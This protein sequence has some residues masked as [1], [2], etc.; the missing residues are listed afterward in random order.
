MLPIVNLFIAIALTLYPLCSK[1]SEPA[2]VEIPPDKQRLIGVK[3]GTVKVAPF[4]KTIRTNGRL[5]FDERASVV[6]SSQIGGWVERLYADYTGYYVKKGDPLLEIYSPELLTAQQEYLNLLNWAS[7]YAS[8]EPKSEIER[9]FLKDQQSLIESAK[10]RLKTWHMT[11]EQ[12]RQIEE[13]KKPIRT[14]AL[15]SAQEGYVTNRNVTLGMRVNAGDSLFTIT[16]TSKLWVIAEIYEQDLPYVRTGM[17]VTLRLSYQPERLFKTKIEFINPILVTDTR[18]VRARM[19]I[20]NPSSE[21]LKAQMLTE[22]EIQ[23]NLG[24]RLSVPEDAVIDTGKKK[25]VYVDKGNGVF[26]QRLVTTGIRADGMIEVL[27]GLK[28]GERIALSANFL[29]DSESKLKGLGQ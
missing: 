3:V 23:L 22:V 20:D 21:I 7:K 28:A 5:E 10:I 16:N 11:D 29:I 13:T 26:E 4:T 2:Q 19:T 12:I 9:L 6:V 14:F 27:K 24:N 25:I 18:T 1:A 8:A 17:P 15:H